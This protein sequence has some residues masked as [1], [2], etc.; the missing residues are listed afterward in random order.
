M[1]AVKSPF[2]LEAPDIPPEAVLWNWGKGTD[3]FIQGQGSWA[4]LSTSL[5]CF[6]VMADDFP[7]LL[8]LS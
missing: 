1:G 3:G 6:H 2:Y 8:E 5:G 7:I 4:L